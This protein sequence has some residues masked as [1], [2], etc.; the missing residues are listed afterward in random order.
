MR[1]A[2]PFGIGAAVFFLVIFLLLVIDLETDTAIIAVPLGFLAAAGAI[3]LVW[4][5]RR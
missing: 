1:Y 3:A 2:L 5:R 4:P